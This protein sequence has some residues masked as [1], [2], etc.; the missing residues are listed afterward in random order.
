MSEGVE[1]AGGVG[2]C[3]VMGGGIGECTRLK[4]DVLE[5]DWGHA[6]IEVR[7]RGPLA[8]HVRKLQRSATISGLAKEWTTA[9]HR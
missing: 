4:F 1:E 3:R 2:R 8:R 5:I 9:L 6:P 7:L